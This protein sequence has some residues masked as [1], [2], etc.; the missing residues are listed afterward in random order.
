MNMAYFRAIQNAKGSSSKKETLT[1]FNKRKIAR[2]YE[3]NLENMNLLRYPTED[4]Y[5][6][7]SVHHQKQE[8]WG[9]YLQST[10]LLTSDLCN[11]DTFYDEEYQDYFIVKN[12]QRTK[13]FW[14][15]DLVAC[16][17]VLKWQNSNRVVCEQ[18][19]VI[20]S[21]SQYNSGERSNKV[22]TL[23]T[24]QIMVRMQITDDTIVLK[25][26][27]RF[28]IDYNTIEPKVYRLTRVDTVTRAWNG[29]GYLEIVF[30]EDTFNVDTDNIEEM[31]CDY[32]PEADKDIQISYRSEPEIRKSGTKT[33]TSNVPVTWS[34]DAGYITIVSMDDTTLKI[35]CNNDDTLIGNT[36]N[37]YAD[38]VSVNMK[39]VGLL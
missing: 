15:L 7:I 3:Q 31:L 36:F 29:R 12:L 38:S 20:I 13:H 4:D 28:F 35:K 14:D 32:L 18:P 37:V 17:Y 9:W 10:A 16:N 39:V 1:E 5:V 21:A 2:S 30:T 6:S 33:F 26:D 11:G 8:D 19:C 23:G 24:N 27:K 25:N 22:M 34:V